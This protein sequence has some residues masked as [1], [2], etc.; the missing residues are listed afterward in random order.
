MH[1]A[2]QSLAGEGLVE[3]R[4]KLGTVVSERAQERP[5]LEIWDIAA[6]ARRLGGHYRFEVIERTTIEAGRAHRSL[7]EVDE[8]TPLLRVVC[9]HY[10][11]AQPLQF[12]ERLI[13]VAAAPRIAG[14][15]FRR[16]SPGR[17]LLRHVPWTEAEHTI[18]AQPASAT[19][20]SSLDIARGSACLVVERRTWNESL[21]V[22]FARM[23]HPGER[24]R[25][26]GRFRPSHM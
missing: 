21:P 24:Y 5:V 11:D 1:K 26:V 18:L 7:L 25:L 22:T 15:R 20:A 13:S 2:L 6:E 14:E 9:V 4:R 19:V 12:E 23:W 10:S 3:R 17:W 16:S 8:G